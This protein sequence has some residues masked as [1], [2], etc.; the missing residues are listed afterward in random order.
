MPQH[1]TLCVTMTNPSAAPVVIGRAV[2]YAG[3]PA[4][5]GSIPYGILQSNLQG[6]GAAAIGELMTVAVAG[7]V[8]VEFGAATP[9]GAAVTCGGSS[10]IVAQAAGQ[11][12][13]GRN[14]QQITAPN[15]R[16]LIEL[17]KE[18]VS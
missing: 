12:I 8:E 18:G 3:N 11:Y 7:I 17:T 15:Q 13:L 14:L 2:D 10:L 1:P 9:I 5:A 16:G 6:V 4:I